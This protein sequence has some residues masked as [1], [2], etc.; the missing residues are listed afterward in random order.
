MKQLR[1]IHDVA[2]P[3]NSMHDPRPES[4][5]V[6]ICIG[7]L[8]DTRWIET[9]GHSGFKLAPE[10]SAYL[11]TV[12]HDIKNWLGDP[13]EQLNFCFSNAVDCLG[14]RDFMTKSF[15]DEAVK[16]DVLGQQRLSD[17]MVVG[18]EYWIL[19]DDYEFMPFWSVVT[20]EST[21]Q[22]SSDEFFGDQDELVYVFIEGEDCERKAAG[23]VKAE[24]LLH[25]DDVRRAVM[26]IPTHDADPIGYY[27]WRESVVDYDRRLQ[28]SDI[29]D[30]ESKAGYLSEPVYRA[31]RGVAP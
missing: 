5:T 11:S 4:W 27:V 25:T 30:V 20:L 8:R 17:G 2:R 24:D 14:F 23:Y 29:T 6:I 3:G 22:S 12:P 18:D 15:G 16:T 13:E 28:F 9:H 26:A 10:V 19:S 31:I 21:P 7:D 1:V